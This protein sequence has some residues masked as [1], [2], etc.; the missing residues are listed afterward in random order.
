MDSEK[1]Y[2]KLVAAG[3]MANIVGNEYLLKIVKFLISL[4]PIVLADLLDKPIVGINVAKA[5]IRLNIIMCSEATSILPDMMD[6]PEGAGALVLRLALEVERGQL[7]HPLDNEDIRLALL[8]QKI[9]LTG[10]D[11]TKFIEAKTVGELMDACPQ[12][13]FYI[14]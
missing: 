1:I 5:M 12:L 7:S 6:D 11:A 13:Y 2:A 10:E 9:G 8:A 4:W 14:Y 3:V